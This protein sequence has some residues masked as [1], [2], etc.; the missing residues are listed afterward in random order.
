MLGIVYITVGDMKNASEI[1]R[2]LV[3]RRLAACVNMFPVSSIYRW[4]ENIEKQNEIAML[5]KTDSSRL[6]EII[7]VVKILHTYDLPAI[8]F[9][10]IEGEQEYLDWVH[11]NSS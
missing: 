8:E 6:D 2:E 3:S 1:A 4:N 9:W 5:V 10:G 7:K 11:V